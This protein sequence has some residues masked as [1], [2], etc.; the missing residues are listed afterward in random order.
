MPKN[1]CLNHKVQPLAGGWAFE[2]TL[3]PLRVR[4]PNPYV[5]WLSFFKF[6]LDVRHVFA[7]ALVETLGN[8]VH[9]L[10]QTDALQYG[11]GHP[12]VFVPNCS[13]QLDA[14]PI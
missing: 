7:D 3:L 8:S 10:P 2:P 5:H 13:W 12:H 6:H 1:M 14:P 9:D 11:C 4:A